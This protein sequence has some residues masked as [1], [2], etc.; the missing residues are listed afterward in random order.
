MPA[1]NGRF[2]VSGGVSRPTLE[3]RTATS[4]P[5]QTAVNPPPSPSRWDVVCKQSCGLEKLP[6]Q[7]IRQDL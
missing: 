2:G 5:V 7:R 4:A 3:C 6:Q 1:G